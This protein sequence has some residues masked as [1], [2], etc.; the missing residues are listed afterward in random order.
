MENFHTTLHFVTIIIK[1]SQ[2]QN[3]ILVYQSLQQL[4]LA[5]PEYYIHYIAIIIQQID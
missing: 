2:L 4:I 1:F 3:G 5:I